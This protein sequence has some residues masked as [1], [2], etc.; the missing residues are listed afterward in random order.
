MMEGKKALFAFVAFIMV[1]GV[2]LLVLP[3]AYA[4]EPQDVPASVDYSALLESID[5]KLDSL[6]TSD[7]VA[8]LGES[9]GSL[10]TSADVQAVG[11]AV[12]GLQPVDNSERVDALNQLFTGVA[13]INVFQWVTLM[14]LLGVLCVLVFLVSYRS[15]T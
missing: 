15:H 3:R 13:S 4:D 8:A 9:V 12:A 7:D 6:A 11:D 5:E 2:F 1:F 14:L 10:A